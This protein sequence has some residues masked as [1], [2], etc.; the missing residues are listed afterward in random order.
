MQLMCHQGFKSDPNLAGVEKLCVT[1]VQESWL[2]KPRTF[3][4]PADFDANKDLV[5][6][7]HIFVA[8]GWNRSVCALVCLLACSEYP[9]LMEASMMCQ[10][11]V[12][13]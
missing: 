10:F 3:F 4:S 8:K 1:L 2:Q 7:G 12:K 6:V 9:P 11:S 5:G 13:L